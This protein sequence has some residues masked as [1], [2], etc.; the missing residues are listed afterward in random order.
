MSFRSFAAALVAL[1]TLA[2]YL[3]QASCQMYDLCPAAQHSDVGND[4]HDASDDG[5]GGNDGCQCACHHFGAALTDVR[6]FAGNSLFAHYAEFTVISDRVT[7]G[8]A[9][10]ID[11]PPQLG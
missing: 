9:A 5:C 11:H 10:R 7:P 2:G 6:I 4:A 3:T 1:I 8:P